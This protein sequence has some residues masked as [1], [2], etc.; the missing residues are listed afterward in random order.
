MPGPSTPLTEGKVAFL[1]DEFEPGHASQQLLDRFLLGY[2]F[3]GGWRV[4]G[5]RRTIVH[6][7]A[8]VWDH[9]LDRRLTDHG[10][11]R[12]G[13]VEAAVSGASGVI[14]VPQAAGAVIDEERVLAMLNAA[15]RGCACFIHGVCANGYQ[16]A[17]ELQSLAARQGLR[18]VSGTALPYAPHLPAIGVPRNAEIKEAMIVLQGSFP[19]ADLRGLEVLLPLVERRKGGE[20]GISRI[21]QM[22]GDNLWNQGRARQWPVELLGPAL[23][24]SSS[25]QGHAVEDGRTEDLVGKAL[26][27]DLATNPRGWVLE[28]RDGLRSTILMLD[29][30]V[31]DI[32]YALQ[33]ARGNQL[34][35]Q[36]F[37]PPAPLERHYNDL[38]AALETFFALGHYPCA[39]GRGMLESLLME[40]MLKLSLMGGNMADISGFQPVIRYVPL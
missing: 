11:M 9:H 7:P 20:A 1:L 12:A 5:E 33:L 2:S 32:T 14:Y 28:H 34:S 27:R 24:R 3:D 26:V 6:T 38:A 13:E 37:E 31:G 16:K 4:P 8:H 17:F 10:L 23:A 29:G 25:P 40:M 30:V 36:V 22:T 35:G 21:H 19:T 39:P 15:P 18:L